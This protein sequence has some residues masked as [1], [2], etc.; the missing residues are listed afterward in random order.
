MKL[1]KLLFALSFVVIGVVFYLLDSNNIFFDDDVF[2][3]FKYETNQ[4][5]ESISD[6][7]DSQVDHFLF[8]NGRFVV[9]CIVKFFCGIL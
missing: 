9:P 2:Y 7:L 8:R 6:I 5:I 1:S 4:R 3:A